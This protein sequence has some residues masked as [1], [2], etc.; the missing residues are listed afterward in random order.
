MFET[1]FKI[2][3]TPIIPNIISRG[4]Y[5]SALITK[6]INVAKKPVAMYNLKTPL[7]TTLCENFS[8]TIVYPC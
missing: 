5:K 4:V 6:N 3:V 8:T 7:F 1:P 2:T